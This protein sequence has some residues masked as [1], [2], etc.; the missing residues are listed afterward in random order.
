MGNHCQVASIFNRTTATSINKLTETLWQVEIKMWDVFHDIAIYVDV[1]TI[2]L[3]I[4]KVVV[5][6]RRIP[7]ERCTLFSQRIAS[8]E[9]ISL[10]RGLTKA[11][12]DVCSGP[13]G[14]VNIKNMLLAGL[15]LL[16]NAYITRD[17]TSYEEIAIKT[18]ELLQGT[19]IAFNK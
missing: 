9:G 11:I 1:D 13:N 7:H 12:L 4:S 19:C 16:L 8:L 10:S 14:C 17:C 5:D 2:N 18:A 6:Y 15:P 3:T